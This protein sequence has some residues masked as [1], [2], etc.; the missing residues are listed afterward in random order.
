MN[1]L[2]ECLFRLRRLRTLMEEEY[3]QW[4][5]LSLED[6]VGLHQYMEK[7]IFLEKVRLKAEH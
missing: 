6:I 7:K 5:V 3:I 1:D 4:M 2:N